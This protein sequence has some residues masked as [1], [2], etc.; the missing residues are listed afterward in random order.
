MLR[1]FWKLLLRGVQ[2][3]TQLQSSSSGAI[4]SP[5]R[6]T[7]FPKALHASR[8]LEPLSTKNLCCKA[9]EMTECAF[10]LCLKTLPPVWKSSTKPLKAQ[11]KKE[12]KNQFM[13]DGKGRA[14]EIPFCRKSK[15][16]NLLQIQNSRTVCQ[17]L[18]SLGE[19][20]YN[21]QTHFEIH[22]WI[23]KAFCAVAVITGCSLAIA[24]RKVTHAFDSKHEYACKSEGNG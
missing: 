15:F 13:Q 19:R 3:Q 22:F 17:W 5:C 21:H 8:G 6:E 20:W 11:N 24:W 9:S 12:G 4:L 1:L 7:L 14:E 18:P 16:T 23:K 2:V 10:L